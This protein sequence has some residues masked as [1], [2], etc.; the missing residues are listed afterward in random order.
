MATH[1][2][3]SSSTDASAGRRSSHSR[4][5]LDEAAYGVL[6]GTVGGSYGPF[7]EHFSPRRNSTTL[8]HRNSSSIGLD[9]PILPYAASPPFESPSSSSSAFDLSP[10]AAS[11]SSIPRLAGVPASSSTIL[12]EKEPDDFLHEFDPALERMLDKQHMKSFSLRAA[13]NTLALCAVVIGIILLFAGWPIYRFV[14]AGGFPMDMSVTKQNASGM[15]PDV[16]V[17]T[18]VDPATP[19]SAYSRKGLDG[20][21]Y[22]LVFSDEFNRDGRTFWPGDDPYWE[23]VDLHYWGTKDLEWY[24]PDAI[25][26]SDGNLVITLTQQ[27]W[28]NLNFRS[29][30]LQSWNKFCFTGGYMEVNLSLPGGPTAQGFWPG[31]WTLGNLARP[32]YG[33]SN[34]GMWPYSYDSCDVGT[35]PNQTWPNGTAPDAAKHSGSQDYGGELSWLIGQRASAC[36]C[37]ADAGEHPGPSPDVGRGA[38]EIDALEGALWRTG[39]RGSASQSI[40]IAPFTSGYNWKNTSPHVEFNPDWTIQQNQWHGSVYQESLSAEVMTDNTSFSGRGYTTYGFEYDPGPDGSIR[41]AINGSSTWTV[42]SSAI[43]PDAAAG[44]GQRIISEEPMSIVLNLAISFAFQEPEW[45]KLKFPASLL[46]D[47]VRVYQK[48]KPK[49][50]CDPPD[51]P[52]SEYINNHMDLYMN[53]NI[54]TFAQSNY[55]KPRNRL[56]AT[57]CS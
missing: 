6:N 51:H 8:I 53:P 13:I 35:L 29:G 19:H 9:P 22:R 32:G 40:Q 5:R 39:D 17:P 52:T 47:Y 21:Q 45:G 15:I 56:S 36:T 34:D 37:P 14:I 30:M 20:E 16:Q 2:S 10:A 41:W 18:L 26:T 43:G 49:I 11:S 42:H 3:S 33:G 31:V 54:S 25:T 50:G 1:S 24:D 28:N 55:T 57:G 23:A 12:W 38:P 48:G 7:P 4:E 44:I 46:I 27:P